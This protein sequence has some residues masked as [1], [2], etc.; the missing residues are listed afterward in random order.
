MIIVSVGADD[1]CFESAAT[2]RFRVWAVDA[3][4]SYVERTFPCTVE[5]VGIVLSILRKT[6][7]GESYDDYDTRMETTAVEI[8]ETQSQLRTF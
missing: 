8:L 5:C 1:W 4:V 2:L 6:E 3:T 7:N